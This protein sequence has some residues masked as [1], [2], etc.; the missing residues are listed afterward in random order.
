GVG[1]RVVGLAEV[2]PL[3]RAPGAEVAVPGG[4]DRLAQLLGRW[5]EA[6]VRECETVHGV[7][8]A[9]GP[10][11]ATPAAGGQPA[12]GGTS[13]GNS[14]PPRPPAGPAATSP[15]PPPLAGPR[16][17]RPPGAAGAS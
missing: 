1:A 9:A 5:I 15:G 3:G 12:A 10:E 17:A 4:G 7:P 11:P 8:P 13:R 14:R 6:V 2:L 16:L